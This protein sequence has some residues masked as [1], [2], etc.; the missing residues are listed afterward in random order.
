MPD[1]T[2][3]ILWEREMKYSDDGVRL[4]IHSGVIENG[5]SRNPLTL[6][7]TVPALVNVQVSM[8]IMNGP[9]SIQPRN[10]TKNQDR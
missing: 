4:P 7:G 6:C 10:A 9:Q 5:R 3:P 2:N 8:H 1:I